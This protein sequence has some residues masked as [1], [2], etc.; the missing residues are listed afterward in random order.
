MAKR[1]RGGKTVTLSGRK[2]KCH[3]KSVKV[4]V[5]GKRAFR[6]GKAFCRKASRK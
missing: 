6:R 4:K 1:A 5:P 3:V 2:F